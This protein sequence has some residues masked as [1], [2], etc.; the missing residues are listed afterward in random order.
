MRSLWVVVGVVGLIAGVAILPVLGASDYVVRSHH[1]TVELSPEGQIIGV[2]LG[3]EVGL[4]AACHQ[5]RGAGSE[6]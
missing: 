3:E 5:R 2:L 1:L 6:S 4:F